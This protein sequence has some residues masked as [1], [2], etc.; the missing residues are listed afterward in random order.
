[1]WGGIKKNE[2]RL[3][4]RRPWDTLSEQAW[5]VSVVQVPYSRRGKV[6]VRVRLHPLHLGG[7]GVP[8]RDAVSLRSWRR[9]LWRS[10]EALY[11]VKHSFAVHV[12]RIASGTWRHGGG[13]SGSGS[14]SSLH[15]FLL[16]VYGHHSIFYAN[17]V[18]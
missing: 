4:S 13:R 7:R 2:H 16:V 1:M 18:K 10:V 12:C 14:S 9:C 5:N 3:M 17:K 6:A 11:L 15:A 8:D